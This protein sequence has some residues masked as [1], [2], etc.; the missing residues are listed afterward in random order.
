MKKVAQLF[1]LVAFLVS[2]G[3]KST[4][5]EVKLECIKRQHSTKTCHYNFTVDGLPYNYVD[6]GCKQKKEDI[7]KKAESGKLALV[8]DW[9]IPCD[10]KK[11]KG[12]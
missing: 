3:M 9:K 12:G 8:K 1:F 2:M 10:P 5:Q 4:Y 11:P 7:V 6:H